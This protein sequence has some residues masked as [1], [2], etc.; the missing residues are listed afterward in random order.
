MEYASRALPGFIL[1]PAIAALAFVLAFALWRTRFISG[2]FLI[3]IVWL[4]YVM[5]ALHEITYTELVGGQSLNAIVSLGV[6]MV[7]GALFVFPRAPMLVQRTPLVVALMTAIVISGLIN[8]APAALIEVLLKWGY[9]I[10]V[11]LC[12]Y[13]HAMR[14]GGRELLR[15]L[16]FAFAAPVAF[17]L[18]S[19]AA[20]VS[21]ATESDGSTSFIGGYNHEAAFSVVMIT[22][23]LVASL[24]P[25][26][27]LVLRAPMLTYG[28]AGVLLANY[29]TALV[30]LAPIAIGYLIFS[31]GRGFAARDRVVIGSVAA[32]VTAACL[33]VGMFLLRDR[34]ADIGVVWGSAGTLLQRPAEF[35]ADQM[36]LLSGRIY[37]WSRYL[38]AYADG[39]LL[40]LLFGFGPDA[41]SSTIGVYAHN[42]LISYLYEFGIVGAVLLV[43]V[44]ASMLVN[45]LRIPDPSLRGQLVLAHVGFIILNLATMPLWLIEGVILYGLLC[46]YTLYLSRRLAPQ[47]VLYVRR[48]RPRATRELVIDG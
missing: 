11:A 21:K 18:L 23:F 12:V 45:A 37:L 46:G 40:Q 13:D 20:G 5:Q 3:A 1:Y 29:R 10:V 8:W 25:R 24:A 22:G 15:T 43:L 34:L 32:L 14:S 38:D 9:F 26:I 6:C 2:Q 16:L 7:G 4:R 42:T 28:I 30:A 48:L 39:S 35:T 33:G 19:V 17:Q 44:W 31:A 36:Q 47:P 41:W 27:P